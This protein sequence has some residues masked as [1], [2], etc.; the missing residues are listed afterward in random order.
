MPKKKDRLKKIRTTTE[1]LEVLARLKDTT[2]WG[3]V[4]RV[5]NRYKMGL[6]RRAFRVGLGDPQK[7]AVTLADMQGQAHGIDLLIRF[8]DNAGKKLEKNE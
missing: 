7:S 2:D 8:V 6:R 4:K 3:I 5:A 1:E